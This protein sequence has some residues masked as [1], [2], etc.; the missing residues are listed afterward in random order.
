M[1]DKQRE[2]SKRIEMIVQA[3]RASGVKITHQRLEIIRMVAASELHPSADEIFKILQEK[4]PM[5]SLDTVYRTLWMLNDLG[6]LTTVGNSRDS[7][8]F[9]ANQRQHHHFRCLRCGLIRDFND[10][11]LDGLSIPAESGRFGKSLSLQVE[12]QGICESCLQKDEEI[13]QNKTTKS[14]D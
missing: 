7:V 8:R 4:L 3:V 1:T 12:V 2:T 10:P 13:T 11:A 14:N 9:D 5:L 6:L